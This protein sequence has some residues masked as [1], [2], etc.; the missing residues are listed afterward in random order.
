MS[1]LKGKGSARINFTRMHRPMRVAKEQWEMV[2]T[3]S[4]VIRYLSSLNLVTC[5]EKK[6]IN[7]IFH[8]YAVSK[9]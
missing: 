2:G 7:C 5:F 4:T 8:V 1:A 6:N 3:N 9:Y